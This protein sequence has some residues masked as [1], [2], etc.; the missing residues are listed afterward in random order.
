MIVVDVVLCALAL[1]GAVPVLVLAAQVLASLPALRPPPPAPRRPSLAVLVPAHDEAGEIAATVAS[2]RPGLASGDRLLVVADN[3]RDATAAAAREAGAEVV[4]RHDPERRGKGYALDFGYRHLV[5]TG[6]PET[7]V[8][9]DADCALG[10]EALDRIARLSAALDGPVQAA[11]RLAPPPQASS[12]LRLATVA[13][14]VKQI[15]RPLGGSRLGWPCGISGT[16]FAV[17][18]RLMGTVGL[19]N[20]HLAEDLKLGLDLALAGHPPRFCPEAEVT[21]A[22]PAGAAARRAQQTRWEHGHLSLI[23]PY[24]GALLRAALHRGDARLAA[25]ALDLCVLP[26]VTL[27]L[28]QAGLAGL[29]LAWWVFGGGAGPLLVSAASLAGLVLAFG[30]AARRWGGGLLRW[31][32]LAAL[33]RLIAGKAGILRRFALRRQT[34]WVRTERAGEGKSAG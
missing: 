10:A 12:A 26:L 29:G 23:L 19:A 20:G 33:P 9:V 13:T 11:Y 15:G 18:T 3:C 22:L 4:E 14:V 32:D 34:E 7:L 5:R 1:A 30:L 16:G 6:L 2:L 8:V 31:Q 17:P 27:A 28:A 25:M 24:A 21:S